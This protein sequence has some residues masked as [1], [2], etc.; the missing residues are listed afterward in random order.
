MYRPFAGSGRALVSGGYE[1][2]SNARGENKDSCGGE[3]EDS[4]ETQSLRL[5]KVKGR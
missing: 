3:D 4:T 1:T 5:E 2:G